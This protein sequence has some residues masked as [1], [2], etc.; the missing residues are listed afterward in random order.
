M[1]LLVG[2][3]VIIIIAVLAVLAALTKIHVF[4]DLE[5]KVASLSRQQA[6]HQHIEALTIA[7]RRFEKA[8]VLPVSRNEFEYYLSLATLTKDRIH[9]LDGLPNGPAVRKKWRK[10]LLAKVRELAAES[11]QESTS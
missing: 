6:E 8:P 4:P 3:T 9:Q 7:A 11:T 2:G 5:Q 1:I 10:D